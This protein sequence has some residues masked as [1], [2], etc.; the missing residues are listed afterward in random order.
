LCGLEGD[1]SSSHVVYEVNP[2]SEEAALT[3]FETLEERWGKQYPLAVSAWER[4]WDR[5]SAMYQFTPFGRCSGIELP[6]D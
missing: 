2:S 3:A 1:L 6:S 4:N 5:I